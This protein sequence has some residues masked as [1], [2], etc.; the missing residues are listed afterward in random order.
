[1][2][3]CFEVLFVHNIVYI[4]IASIGLANDCYLKLFNEIEQRVAGSLYALGFVE[5]RLYFLR[6][7]L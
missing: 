7:R 2:A 6:V 4:G 3:C 1:M 5:P